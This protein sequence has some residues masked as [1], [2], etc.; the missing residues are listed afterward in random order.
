MLTPYYFQRYILLKPC[1]LLLIFFHP[2]IGTA[3]SEN[4]DGSAD[5]H[6]LNVLGFGFYIKV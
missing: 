5:G 6:P 3:L 2:N 4:F 1:Q